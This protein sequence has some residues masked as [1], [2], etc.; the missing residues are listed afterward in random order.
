MEIH[1]YIMKR[2]HTNPNVHIELKDL[3][4]INV[5]DL[6]SRQEELE[7]LG[8]WGL[9]NFHPLLSMGSIVASIDD[10]RVPENNSFLEKLYRFESHQF[11]PIAQKTGLMTPIMT[12]SLFPDTTVAEELVKHDEGPKVEYHCNSCSVDRSCK[13]Y[14]CQKQEDFDLCTDCFSNGKFGSGMPSFDFILMEPAKFPG[15]SD[16][17]WTDEETLLLLEALEPMSVCWVLFPP[18][19]TDPLICV[20]HYTETGALTEPL[21]DAATNPYPY[22][23]NAT[24]VTQF[25]NGLLDSTNDLLT[26]TTHIRDFLVHSKE[27][28]A[29]SVPESKL[30]SSTTLSFSLLRPRSLLFSLKFHASLSLKSP[31]STF[32]AFSDAEE[33]EEDDEEEDLDQDNISTDKYD[34][35]SG[36]ASD[37]ADVFA[38]HGGFKWQRVD[39]LC[40]EVR[41]FGADLI[42]VDELASVYDFRIDKFQ[43]QVILAFLRGFSV[44]VS[45]PT[46]SRK[47]LIAEAATEYV[48]GLL[49]VSVKETTTGYRNEITITNDQ[50]K[51]SAEEIIRIIHEAENYQVDDRKFMKKANT[52]N[53]LDDYV[54]KMRNALNNKNINSKLC[55]QE[56]EK[57]KSV[58][59]KVTDLLEGDNQ[60]YEIE[61]FEDHLNELV[62]LFDRVIGNSQEQALLCVV[63]LSLNGSQS[64]STSANTE[65]D[66]DK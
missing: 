17:K 58:I 43:R 23:S 45:A 34:D 61:V 18:C 39:K 20:L 7:F 19:T 29:K 2:F 60:P 56:R 33:D 26:F 49:S 38:R 21:W 48:N 37:E 5:G 22:P 12:S 52:M 47:T 25:V 27:F 65:V 24:F 42:D 4:E 3:S 63:H 53:A 10:D 62:N 15:F 36:E 44:V 54:Y 9:I 40:N 30:V 64:N 11:S 55:L 50:K 28:S 8:Y 6:G 14:H 1:N 31:A 13:R 16:G 51:L 32:C 59:S 41:E 46:S 35:V 57:I 66:F